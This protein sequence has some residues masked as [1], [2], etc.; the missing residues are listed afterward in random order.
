MQQIQKKSHLLKIYIQVL[1]ILNIEWNYICSLPNNVGHS[2]FGCL[3]SFPEHSV[4]PQLLQ[5]EMHLCLPVA[6]GQ[7]V[8]SHFQHF[9]AARFRSDSPLS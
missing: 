5:A 2:L 3:L 4:D 1:N 6:P 7:S 9:L 8:L